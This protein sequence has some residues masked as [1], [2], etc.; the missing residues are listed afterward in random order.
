M[1]PKPDPSPKKSGPAH[2]YVYSRENL[3]VK[4]SDSSLSMEKTDAKEES[5]NWLFTPYPSELF[6]ARKK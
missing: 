4:P 1:K 2:L 3:P 5:L 6:A